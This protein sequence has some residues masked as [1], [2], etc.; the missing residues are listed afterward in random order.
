M[1]GI[2]RAVC[3]FVW[4]NH[5]N[6]KR[7]LATLITKLIRKL[8][9]LFIECGVFFIY[10]FYKNSYLKLFQAVCLCVLRIIIIFTFSV[11]HAITPISSR[12][13][14]QNLKQL[15]M[16]SLNTSLLHL[17]L[18]FYTCFFLIPLFHSYID[19]WKKTKNIHIYKNILNNIFYYKLSLDKGTKAMLHGDIIPPIFCNTG[20][21][22]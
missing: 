12:H 5:G 6:L 10:L 19:A 14:K 4:H 18:L 11:S 22:Y 20:L 7:L 2:L 8:T 1:W 17:P 16:R 15:L 21:S 3:E 9:T 13:C